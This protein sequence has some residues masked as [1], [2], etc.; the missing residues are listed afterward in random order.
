[1]LYRVIGLMSGS[2]LDGLDIVYTH[3]EESGGKWSYEIQKTACSPYPPQW[4]QKLRD[5]TSLTAL[6]YQLLHA[7]YGHYIGH[8]VNRFMDQ[9]GFHY[10]VQLICSH[11]HTSFHVPSGKMTAQLG[12]GAAIAAVT[13]IHVIS[14][15][16]AMDIALGGQGAPI[17]PIGEKLL[18]GDHDFFLNLGGIANLS[19]HRRIPAE[20][21]RSYLAFDVCPANRVLNMIAQEDSREFDRD[22][23]LASCGKADSSLLEQLNQMDYYRLPY[24]KSLANDFGTNVLFPLL[25]K[26]GI[27]V[28]DAL[29]TYTEHIC[30]QIELAVSGLM[31]VRESFPAA[32]R[33]LV[34]GG[35]AHNLFLISRLKEYLR[36]LSVELVVPDKTL[37]DFKEALIMG[38]V[39]VLRWREESNVLASVTGAF[40]DSVGGAVWLGHS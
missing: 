9:Y 8:E 2:S 22:G 18:L 5:A 40:R 1:M 24:P 33:M 19:A 37:V 30:M 13:G 15:L 7:E 10:Q 14:D 28:P 12:D 34:T 20:D 25:R 31:S 16:R 21:N 3:L 6:E 26:T 29:R 39:G 36:P 32:S 4:I 17:V 23:E 11:G 27:S 35:G 38:L